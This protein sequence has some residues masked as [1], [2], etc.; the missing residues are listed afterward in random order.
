MIQNI[1]QST[2]FF[3]FGWGGDL[4]TDFLKNKGNET[5]EYIHIF[6]KII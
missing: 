3:F 5:Q 4:S 6:G 2:F 1:R